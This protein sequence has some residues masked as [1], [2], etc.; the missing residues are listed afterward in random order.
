MNHP[1]RITEYLEHIAQAIQRATRYLLHL[2][3]AAALERSDQ[4]R[5]AVVR[6]S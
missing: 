2:N 1:E 3:D 5:S 6:N 4:V